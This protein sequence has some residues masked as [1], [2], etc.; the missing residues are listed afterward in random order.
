MIA[1]RT[2]GTPDGVDVK[3]TTR[4]ATG[5]TIVAPA[6]AMTAVVQVI[7]AANA[8]VIKDILKLTLMRA[9]A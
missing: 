7:S 6:T 5:T 8:E 3:P 4:L 1:L 2:A 9:L